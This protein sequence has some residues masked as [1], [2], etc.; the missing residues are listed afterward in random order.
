MMRWRTKRTASV[1]TTKRS[2]KTLNW[3]M[4]VSKLLTR[5]VSAA[6]RAVDPATVSERVATTTPIPC[7]RTTVVAAK[8]LFFARKISFGSSVS[9]SATFSTSSDSPVKSDSSIA[10]SRVWKKRMSAGRISPGFTETISPG[11]SS[12]LMTVISFP[13]R[14]MV[15]FA[16]KYFLSDSRMLC[17]LYS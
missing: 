7:P 14:T 12:V 6:R 11:I 3:F 4:D 13:S 16:T 8:P 1:T 5:F 2:M 9:V 15:V 10:N 17:D